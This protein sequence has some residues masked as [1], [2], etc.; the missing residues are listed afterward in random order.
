VASEDALLNG[1]PEAPPDRDGDAIPDQYDACPKVPGEATAER[2]THGCPKVVDTDGDGVADAEDVCPREAGIRP[3]EGNGC[4]K[5]AEPAEPTTAELVA[6]VIVLSQ[7][8]QFETG[9]ATLRSESDAILSEVARILREHAE[10]ELVEVQGHTDERGSDELNLKLG[11]ERAEAV[12]RWL[13]ARGIGADRLTAK[14]YGSSRPIADN[15]TD[16]GRAKN[17]RV[18]LRVLKT[19][20]PAPTQ[21]PAK[22][23]GAK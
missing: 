18:E 5:P 3:P 6:D 19:K 7:M 2:R 15:T 23:E 16:E 12:V 9:T 22:K 14:G 1:C 8:V 10:L 11:Q 17:R 20:D 13:V 21:D 4:P